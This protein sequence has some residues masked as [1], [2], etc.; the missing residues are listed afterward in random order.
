MLKKII[1][2]I[3]EIL[4]TIFSLLLIFSL[5]F[6]NTIGSRDYFQKMVNKSD[7]Y[8]LMYAYIM[9]TL[10]GHTIQLDLDEETFASLFSKEKIREDVDIVIDGI[11]ENKKVQ[12]DSS[13]ISNRIEEIVTNKLKENN[14]APSSDERKAIDELKKVVGDIYQKGISYSTKLISE[15]ASIY[16][17]M[18][19][20][21]WYVIPILFVIVIFLGSI[22]LLL[23]KKLKNKLRS[24]ATSYLATGLCLLT[25]VVLLQSKFQRITIFNKA[26]T[27]LLKT[28]INSIFGYILVIGIVLSLISLILIVLTSLKK[29]S[30]Q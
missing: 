15:L 4:L 2:R 12:I 14:R 26:F 29:S 25:L 16:T 24:L 30:S 1:I 3:T 23:N 17:K 21:K 6:Y 9:D 27:S 11:Y 22:L 7:Y 28:T 8:D 19:A 18:N 13:P 20:I 5:V 10:E